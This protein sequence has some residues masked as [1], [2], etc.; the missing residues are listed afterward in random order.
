MALLTAFVLVCSIVGSA[1]LDA[2][3]SAEERAEEA[4]VNLAL[5]LERSLGKDL[6]TYDI[7]L[8][9]IARN[10]RPANSMASIEQEISLWREVRAPGLGSVSLLDP[11]GT[12]LL[13]D[14]AAA[15]DGGDWTASL[16]AH[17]LDPTMGLHAGEIGPGRNTGQLRMSISRRIEDRQGGFAGIVGGNVKLDYFRRATA[18]FR[19]GE[20]GSVTLLTLDGRL[21]VASHL[22]D[23]IAGMDVSRSPVMQ[24]IRSDGPGTFKA[25]SMFDG[26]ERLF[27]VARLDDLPF[28]LVVGRLTSEIYAGW[29][30]RAAAT[31]A[32]LLGAMALLG[33]LGSELH[34]ELRRRRRAESRAWQSAQEATAAAAELELVT[35]NSEDLILKVD[36]NGTRNFVS[37]ASERL[38][39]YSPS[40]LLHQDA[41]SL[42]HPEDAPVLRQ[43]LADLRAG[44]AG[45][46]QATYRV[47]TRGGAWLDVEARCRALPDGSGAI[48]SVRDIAARI[49]LEEKLRHAQK[50][51]GIGQLTAGVA[52]DFNNMLQGQIAGLELLLDRVAGDA[53]ASRLAE[54]AIEAAEVGARLTHSLLAF[55][56]KQV[57]RPEQ[58]DLAALMRELTGLLSRTLGPSVRLEVQMEPGLTAPFA[59]RA[60]LA[61]ALLNLCL[62]ARDSMREAGG[63]ILLHAGPALGPGEAPGAV[64]ISVTDEGCGMAPDVLARVCEPF[65]TTKK[66]GEGSGLGLSMVQG[67]AEQSGGALILDSRPG[68]GT[69]ATICLPKG[70]VAQG[71]RPGGPRGTVPRFG[72]GGAPMPRGLRVLLVDDDASV[73]SNLMEALRGHGIAATA[74]PNGKQAVGLLE[75]RRF[76]VLV[77]DYGMPGMTGVELIGHARRIDPGLRALL[78]TGYVDGHMQDS[79]PQDVTVLHKPFRLEELLAELVIEARPALAVP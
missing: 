45:P 2:R 73:L 28:Y 63:R 35:G 17:R 39:G 13:A 74:A 64:A 30:A 41:L 55:A 61:A 62:N 42:V 14:P 12:S 9:A 37:P 34:R 53:E 50:M 66:L 8:K 78:I 29:S 22:P 72:G 48:V 38:L 67:F 77:T 32:F 26:K 11:Q 23:E 56:R 16:D 75:T 3:R 27:S 57:L 54:G 36:W 21:V 60:L 79:V 33:L 70:P 71:G 20:G 4:L 49:G 15:A 69:C 47:R 58:V 10:A 68:R 6:L 43:L 18:D 51:E 65:F 59:D 5:S 25:P 52:H 40:E 76:D 24:R 1:L 19:L 7:L 46:A 31:A 44:Q